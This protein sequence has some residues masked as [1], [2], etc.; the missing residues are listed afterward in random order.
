MSVGGNHEG[1]GS[2]RDLSRA[3]AE[4]I[5]RS[6][7]AAFPDGAHGVREG[8]RWGFDVGFRQGYR[9][10]RAEL[11]QELQADLTLDKVP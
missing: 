3:I 6:V 10:A 11:A 9:H 5:E 1:A 2:Y 7:E 4:R 8:F